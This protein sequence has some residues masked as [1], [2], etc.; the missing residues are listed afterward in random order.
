MTI[1][2]FNVDATPSEGIENRGD[3]TKFVEG[4]TAP[5]EVGLFTIDNAI[6]RYLTERVVPTVVQ[7]NKQIQVPVLYGNPE[8]WKSAQVDGY[9]RDKNGKISLPL[10]MLRRTSME[11]STINSPVNKYQNYTYSTKWNSRNI[12]DKFTALNRITPSEVYHTSIIPDYYTI[13]YEA[14][15]WTEYMEQMNSLVETISFESNEYWGDEVGYKFITAIDQFQYITEIPTTNDRLVRSSFNLKV[16]AYILP[17]TA[18]N[19]AGNTANTNKLVYSPKKVVF[20]TEVVSTI[21]K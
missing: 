9:I 14:M 7:N 4:I 2:I 13:V 20:S 21:P 18:L 10:I 6:L 12:Y 11:K 16:N 1:P 19:K 17:K 5:M 8:R 15:I 3:Q